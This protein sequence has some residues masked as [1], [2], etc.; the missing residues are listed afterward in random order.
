MRSMQL[1]DY[2]MNMYR[3]FDGMRWPTPSQGMDRLKEMI[4]QEWIF[5]HKETEMASVL[6]NAEAIIDAYEQLINI[7][8]KRRDE[9]IRELRKGP[10]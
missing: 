2:N 7:S 9:I 6:Y 8:S 4:H 1:G 3:K 10:N 5:S